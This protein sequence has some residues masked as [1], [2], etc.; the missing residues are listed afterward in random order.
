M[1]AYRDQRLVASKVKTQPDRSCDRSIVY[2]DQR[3]VASK[4]KT[5][6]IRTYSGKVRIVINALWH[7]R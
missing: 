7:L 3:L 6:R 2:R 5:Q 4:V 1:E